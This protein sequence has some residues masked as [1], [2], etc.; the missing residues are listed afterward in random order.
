MKKKPQKIQWILVFVG[1]FL[2]MATY[3]YYP[4]INK[5]KLIENQP[6]EKNLQETIGKKKSTTFENVE[7]KGLYDLD[8]PFTVKS[9]EAYILDD[10][11]PDILYMMS[12]HATLYLS[13]GRIV[14][15]ISNKGKYNK[16]TQD[17][18]FE[19]DVK[20]TDG[21]TKIFAENLDLLATENFVK[22]YNSVKLNHS[23]G[24]LRADKIDYDFETKY[25]KVSMFDDKTVKMK[26]IR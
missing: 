20:A 3:F 15:I 8:K 14:D 18:F 4:Y 10:E 7:Y 5:E 12:M 9:E 25:F 6:V 17:C 22:I 24:T 13:D 16:V 19:E 11:N 26:V 2:I 1:I 21:E 23:T